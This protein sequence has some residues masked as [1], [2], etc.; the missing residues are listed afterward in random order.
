MIAKSIYGEC[1]KEARRA[2]TMQEIMECKNNPDALNVGEEFV[3]DQNGRKS[4]IKTT[5]DWM[6]LIKWKDGQESWIPL[7]DLKKSYPT[8]IAEYVDRNGLKDEPVFKWWVPFTLKKKLQ[9]VSAVKSRMRK[10][11]HKFG[12]EIPTTVAE[13]LELDKYN[14]NDFWRRAIIKE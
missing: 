14:D 2:I 13:A 9:I 3:T 8:K 11:T 4:R 12:V 6:F 10:K 7:K 5:K 1:D